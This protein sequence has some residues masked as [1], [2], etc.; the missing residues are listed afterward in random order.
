MHIGMQSILVFIHFPSYL[1]SY[2][3]QKEET[4]NLIFMCSA[5]RPAA[6]S[7]WWIGLHMNLY[8]IFFSWGLLY[9]NTRHGIL[10]WY[11][12]YLQFMVWNWTRQG[13]A[14]QVQPMG[15]IGWREIEPVPVLN[16]KPAPVTFP[17]GR[18][19]RGPGQLAVR[20]HP[21][22]PSHHR[23]WS[24]SVCCH[25]QLFFKSRACVELCCFLAFFTDLQLCMCMNSQPKVSK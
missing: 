11:W 8:P 18:A 14:V 7:W 6:A 25:L 2:K 17:V 9:L 12:Y 1:C 16:I 20:S 4:G 3:L 15:M 21:S 24:P 10:A 22:I 19:V 13:G 23:S 5:T